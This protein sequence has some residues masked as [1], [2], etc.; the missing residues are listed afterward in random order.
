MDRVPEVVVVGVASRDL[1]PADA[2]GWRLGGGVSYVGL[3]LARLGIRTGVLIGLDR[4]AMAAIELDLLRDAGA[5]VVTVPVA[6][7]PVFVNV[8][9]PSGRVQECVDR[10]DPVRVAALPERWRAARAWVLAPVAAELSEAW[11]SVPPP[12][13]TVVLGWQG[14]LRRL[15]P[16]E[17]VHRLAPARSP[18][19]A[20]ADLVGVSR[21]D[22]DPG[23]GAHA[24]CRLLHPGATLLLTRGASGGTAATAGDQGPANARAW[25]AILPVRTIDP[26]GA[27]DVFLGA[28]AAA[29]LSPSMFAGLFDRLPGPDL[30]LLAGAAAAS[31]VIEDHGL[32]G[33]PDLAGVRARMDAALATGWCAVSGPDPASDSDAES[34]SR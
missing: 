15:V 6:H 9:R 8:E 14:L 22:V 23:I 30:D 5:E 32:L 19:V 28:M 16:G 4:P 21:D 2:R 17:T 29:R 27:G 25:P 34:A 10:S 20:R 24:L 26:T 1:D 7:G 13:A 3:L 31:L 12:G 33:V 18:I 11:A